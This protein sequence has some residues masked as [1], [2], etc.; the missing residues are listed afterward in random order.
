M[1][2]MKNNQINCDSTS[3]KQQATFLV[4]VIFFDPLPCGISDLIPFLTPMALQPLRCLTMC[5]TLVNIC[6]GFAHPSAINLRQFEFFFFLICPVF[7]PF[8]RCTNQKLTKKKLKR[9]N[10]SKVCLHVFSRMFFFFVMFGS[11]ETFFYVCLL[12]SFRKI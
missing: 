9:T 12:A 8:A 4:I 1:V 2:F 7:S 5:F 6:K 3:E 10:Y 11:N